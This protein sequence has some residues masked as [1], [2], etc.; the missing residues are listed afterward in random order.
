MFLHVLYH[1]L[2]NFSREEPLNPFLSDHVWLFIVFP[3]LGVSKKTGKPIKP[4]KPEKKKP[5]KPIK[6]LKKPAGSVRFRFYNQKTEKTEPNRNRKK[7]EQNRK[8]RA[9]PKKPS[10]NRKKPSQNR[11]NRA[12]P[13]F[14]L[15]N[16]T[17][18]NRN[19]SVW[20]GFGSVSVFFFKKKYFGLVTFF[21]KN[22]TEPKMITPT[23]YSCLTAYIKQKWPRIVTH[24]KQ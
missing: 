5:I 15:K 22:R 1:E 20:P 10:Q 16:R 7:T 6:F 13:V 19:R 2:L 21:D 24:S 14:A 18:P 23:H 8:N 4:R 17:E 12:K 11:E 3:L 9:K